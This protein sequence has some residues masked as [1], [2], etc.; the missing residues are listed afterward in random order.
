MNNLEQKL[1]TICHQNYIG[2]EKCGECGGQGVTYDDRCDEIDG[3]CE[4]C[5]GKGYTIPL[6]FGCEVR[7]MLGLSPFRVTAVNH[8]GEVLLNQNP[9]WYRPFE[10]VENLGKP[11]TLQMVLR[12]LNE[13]RMDV[14]IDCNYITYTENAKTDVSC[15]YIKYDITKD[16]KDQPEVLQAILTIVR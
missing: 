8:L 12:L 5:K 16:L 14:H 6:E 7:T 13:I 4:H 11:L 3:D 2:S 15:S 10:I 1:K 9:V